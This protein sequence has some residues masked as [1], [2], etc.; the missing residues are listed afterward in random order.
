MVKPTVCRQAV[1]VVEAELKLSQRQACR[2]LG[3]S[4]SSMR[5]RSVRPV[6][7]K[8]LEELKALAGR[9]P[10]RGYRYLWMLLRRSGRRVNHKRIYR[11]YR[12]E[13]LAVRTKRRKRMAAAPRLV[14]Q[15]ATR[16]NERWSMDF[17]SDVTET[18]RRFRIFAVVDNFSRRC[19]ALEVDTSFTGAR[20]A[21][22]LRSLGAGDAHRPTLMSDNGPEFTS[23]AMDQWASSS[24][25][26]LHFIRPGKPVE[27]A[28]IESF[29]GRLRDECLNTQW[30]ADLDHAR[31]V[32]SAWRDD[33]NNVRPHG[34]LDGRTPSEYE[35]DFNQRLTQSVA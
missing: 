31:R 23:K 2:A 13:G 19:V 22:V 6:P 8:L 34:S 35:R 3:V 18:G 9:W 15:T 29:N 33:Y 27:N 1:G 16:P 11:L 30:F 4:R 17:V 5:Y 21:R 14:L 24:R 7:T 32:L 12:A 28:F 25:V 10:R 26:P 20:L